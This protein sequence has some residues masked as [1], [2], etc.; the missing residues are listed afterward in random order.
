MLVSALASVA[1]IDRAPSTMRDVQWLVRVT[2]RQSIQRHVNRGRALRVAFENG[3]MGD[4]GIVAV[5]GCVRLV[6][7]RIGRKFRHARAAANPGEGDRVDRNG[8]GLPV[9]LRM[10]QN[11]QQDYPERTGIQRCSERYCPQFWTANG[12]SGS[13]PAGLMAEVGLRWWRQ[14]MPRTEGDPDDQSKG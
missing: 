2:L 10:S 7:W 3:A 5:Q 9:M 8:N 14:R 1:S 12:A 11:E 13:S 4:E 6:Q